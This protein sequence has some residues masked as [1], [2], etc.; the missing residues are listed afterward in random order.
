MALRTELLRWNN[1]NMN[2]LIMDGTV[3]N[4]AVS[5]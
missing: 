4:N 3:R 1:V 2:T 5:V